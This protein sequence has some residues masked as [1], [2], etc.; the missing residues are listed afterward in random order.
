ML[1][2]ESDF[3]WEKI[4]IENFYFFSFYFVNLLFFVILLMVVYV[5]FF[6]GGYIKMNGV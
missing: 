2:N 1:F 6:L 5:F 4:F 3:R